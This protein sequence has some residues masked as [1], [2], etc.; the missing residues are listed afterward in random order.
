MLYRKHGH[1]IKTK[2]KHRMG[3]S[4]RSCI[5]YYAGIISCPEKQPTRVRCSRV[6]LYSGLRVI[7]FQVYEAVIVL[8][9][10]EDKSTMVALLSAIVCYFVTPAHSYCVLRVVYE[11]RYVALSCLWAPG[12]RLHSFA[13]CSV[14]NK[15]QNSKKENGGFHSLWR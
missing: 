6:P 3:Q 1:E 5:I 13:R 12:A 14:G 7:N 10:S 11:Y 2:Q 8:G 9:L 15:R 4:L